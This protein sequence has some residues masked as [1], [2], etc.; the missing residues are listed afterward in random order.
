[1]NIIKRILREWLF[2]EADK[3]NGTYAVAI[4]SGGWGIHTPPSFIMA[5]HKASNGYVLEYREVN[6][7][8]S[9]KVTHTILPFGDDLTQA[10]TTA[11]V[12]GVL[13]K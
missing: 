3:G 6:P 9:D 2:P 4:N 8:G 1:M 7:H 13:T 5:V 12:Q 10:I 11:L